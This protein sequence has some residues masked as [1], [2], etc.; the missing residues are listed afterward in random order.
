[1]L[2]L[3]ACLWG[4][5]NDHLL[6]VSV[7]PPEERHCLSK[8]ENRENENCD[9]GGQNAVSDPEGFTLG[10]W[11]WTVGMP[12]VGSLITPERILSDIRSMIPDPLKCASN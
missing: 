12:D 5:I 3:S 7:I 10:F 1:V 9:R 2:D 11:L 6:G 4:E 8:D